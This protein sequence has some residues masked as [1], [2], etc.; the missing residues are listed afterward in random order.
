MPE[1]HAQKR[2]LAGEP[3][4]ALNRNARLA[5]RARPGR[6]DEV[7]GLFRGD[8]V[9]GDLIVAMDLDVERRVD[10]SQPLDEVVGEAVV[11]VNQ[12]DN[13]GLVSCQLESIVLSTEYPDRWS[14]LCISSP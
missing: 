8:L 2:H 11:V 6:N 1:T 12:K 4:D 13:R 10:L 5:G 7:R 9:A 14:R 3:L